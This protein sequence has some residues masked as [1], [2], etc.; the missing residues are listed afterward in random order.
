MRLRLELVPNDGAGHLVSPALQ[1]WH[2]HVSTHRP[3]HIT[4]TA[5][6]EGKAGAALSPRVRPGSEAPSCRGLSQE[7]D[8]L[9]QRVHAGLRGH[10][11][12]SQGGNEP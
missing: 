6:Q 5:L 8:Q 4:A 9:T 10:T 3:R 2:R 12:G 11:Q 7:G 1:A